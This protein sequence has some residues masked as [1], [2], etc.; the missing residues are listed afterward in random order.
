MAEIRDTM[1]TAARPHALTALW[2]DSR[3]RA[4]LLFTGCFCI[5]ISALALPIDNQHTYFLRGLALAGNGFLPED[6]LASAR[7]PFV[8]FSWIVAGFDSVGFLAG[9]RVVEAL[10]VFAFAMSA[11]TILD[12]AQPAA[13]RERNAHLLLVLSLMLVCLF[14]PL[15]M[16]GLAGQRVLGMADRLIFGTFLEPTYTGMY[17]QPSEF[18]ILLILS[19]ALFVS[20]R[21][22]PSYLLAALA[23]VFHQSYLLPG[24]MLV[25]AYATYDLA[26]GRRPG[27]ALRGG[28]AALL[29]VAPIIVYSLVNFSAGE[30][31]TA[32][33][34]RAILAETRIPHH[35]RPGH[36]F[37]RLAGLKIAVLACGVGL[38]FYVNR[39]LG[40]V[41][42]VVS[43]LSAL[44][45]AVALLADSNALFLLF[46]WRV[47]VALMPLAVIAAC[48][49]LVRVMAA[50][51]LAG[52][53]GTRTCAI[54]LIGLIVAP[55]LFVFT[56]RIEAYEVRPADAVGTESVPQFREA[57]Y[58]AMV[59]ELRKEA[60]PGRV[61]L[62]DPLR[63]ESF[64]LLAG[65]PTYVD[66]KSHPYD[67]AGLVEWRD[68][69]FWARDV[70]SGR[71]ACDATLAADMRDRGITHIIV[72]SV[73]DGI[74]AAELMDC[75]R[76]GGQEVGLDGEWGRYG[77]VA[78]R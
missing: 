8:V 2:R 43:L 16:Q 41:M 19:V 48:I 68:R 23:G 26:L 56:Q 71:S 75:L 59:S 9:L 64:R 15:L 63:F 7:S 13:P 40:F 18:G 32:E 4:A 38:A 54:A 78:L 50:H 69:L 35:A 60:G 14:L 49:S 61:Y 20:G 34:A 45:T 37:D 30:P 5:G 57:E 66:F 10:L 21:G 31:G 77:I 73:A 3:M 67:P 47:T 28:V 29:A 52:F 46:P 62:H 39:R 1:M 6:W 74:G 36:W 24:A 76:R 65:L 55:A 51:P 33:Q 42:A 44:L 11:L 27:L 22:M 25:A 53:L 70:L 72:D 58:L 12:A 17:L